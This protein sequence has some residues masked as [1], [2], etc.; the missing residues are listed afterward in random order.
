MKRWSVVG[1]LA[2]VALIW[3]GRLLPR[4]LF[5]RD[6]RPTK[7]GR[8][9]NSV[10]GGLFGA[11]PLPGMVALET[12]GRRSGRVHAIPVVIGEHNGDRYLVSMLGERSGWV[13]NIR[14]DGGRAVI[15]HGRRTPVLLEEVPVAERA[16]IIK[17][18]LRVAPE[19]ARTSKRIWMTR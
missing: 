11:L 2:V 17:S 8:F 15:R 12:R 18:Y 16:P 10:T 3:G 19:R 6:A 1:V 4:R 13:P 9:V 5:Y 14:A 7:L